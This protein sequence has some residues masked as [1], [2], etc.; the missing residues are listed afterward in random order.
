MF[1]AL[2]QYF[3][4]PQNSERAGKLQHMCNKSR[5]AVQHAGLCYFCSAQEPMGLRR[6]TNRTLAALLHNRQCLFPLDLFPLF[7]PLPSPRNSLP[8]VPL[9]PSR[10]VLPR[11]RLL[12][13]TGTVI[14]EVGATVLREGEGRKGIT[15]RIYPNKQ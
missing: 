5:I 13:I 14:S 1:S 12:M 7:S 15:R 8:S 3:L 6:T 11:S 9:G 2:V 10:L 4:F